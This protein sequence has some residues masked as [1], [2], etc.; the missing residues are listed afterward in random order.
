MSLIEFSDL[1]ISSVIGY[2]GIYVFPAEPGRKCV[3]R[4]AGWGPGRPPT[5]EL[6]LQ[7]VSH[8]SLRED[9]GDHLGGDDSFTGVG[10]IGLQ[11][12]V[13]VES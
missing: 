1:V 6:S 12:D 7:G 10:I 8:T 9:R 2:F 5:R 3:R 11:S 4:A 13:L